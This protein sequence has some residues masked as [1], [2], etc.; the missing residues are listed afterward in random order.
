[1]KILIVDDHPI[2]TEGL[3]SVL[4]DSKYDIS[5][6]GVSS[7]EDAILYLHEKSNDIDLVLTDLLMPGMSGN[8]FIRLLND[9]KFNISIAVIS[10]VNQ[11]NDIQEVIDLGIKSFI[12]KTY[13]FKDVVKALETI[14]EEG[15]FMPS[16]LRL[17]LQDYVAL[18]NNINVSQRQIEVLHLIKHG[19]SNKQIARQLDI[20]ESTVK[21]HLRSLFESLG[22]SNRLDCVNQAE[23]HGLLNNKTN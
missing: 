11:I 4:S 12:P 13:H 23:K 7:A 6:V 18:K 16:D 3:K 15:E 22:A 8:E 10:A 17:E 5:I 20:A 1:M 14:I 19:L 2:Y 21:A 9:N